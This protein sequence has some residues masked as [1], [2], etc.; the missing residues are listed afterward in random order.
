MRVVFRRV[1]DSLGGAAVAEFRAGA[2]MVGGMARRVPGSKAAGRRDTWAVSHVS[3]SDPLVVALL[4][5]ILEGQAAILAELRAGRATS[6]ESAEGA[7]DLLRAIE[8]ACG[9]LPFTAADLIEHAAL[10]ERAEL[11]AAIVGCIGT[12]SARKLGKLLFKVEGVDL[13][14]LAVHRIRQGRDGI[15]WR[16]ASLRV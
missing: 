15:E 12:A 3:A 14:G 13:D 2:G 11:A 6:R 4:E 7:A 8:S 1:L 5:K 9:A 10:P 16:V